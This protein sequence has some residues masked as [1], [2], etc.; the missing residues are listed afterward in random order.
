M[1]EI[2]F[3][4]MLDERF[5]RVLRALTL[6]RKSKEREGIKKVYF[7]EKFDRSWIG[8]IQFFSSEAMGEFAK[9]LKIGK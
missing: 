7:E 1:A 2:I 8:K 3:K 6:M 5:Y 4:G 9:I